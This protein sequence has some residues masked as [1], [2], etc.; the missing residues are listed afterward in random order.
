MSGQGPQRPGRRAVLRSVPAATGDAKS[1][2]HVGHHL[3]Q[4]R[5][6]RGLTQERAAVSASI[7]R[8]TLASLE[9]ARFPNPKLSTLILL[10]QCYELRSLDELLGP[11]PAAR[12]AHAWE[13]S[14]E[15]TSR[16]LKTSG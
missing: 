14:G 4:L 15:L 11:M 12:V 3:R 10:M 7:T 1:T 6:R 13:E 2:V 9:K 16:Q 8:N 5:E